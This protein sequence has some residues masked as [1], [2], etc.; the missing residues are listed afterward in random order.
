MLGADRNTLPAIRTL[1]LRFAAAWHQRS[2][3]TGQR[4]ERP[5]LPNVGIHLLS[6]RGGLVEQIDAERDDERPQVRARSGPCALIGIDVQ[7]GEQPAPGLAHFAQP[8]RTQD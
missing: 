3:E 8:D 4:L 1:A 5:D 2:I 6:E 7:S